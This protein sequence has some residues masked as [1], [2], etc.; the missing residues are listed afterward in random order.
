MSDIE[1]AVTPAVESDAD[2]NATTASLGRCLNCEVP[3][4]GRWCANCGQKHLD[5]PPTMAL[6]FEELIAALTH[7]DSRF[8]RTLKALLLRPGFLAREFFDGRRVSY[9]PPVRLYLGI[10]LVFF[11]WLSI[12]AA[13]DRE[14]QSDASEVVDKIESARI[15]QLGKLAQVAPDFIDP[16]SDSAPDPD[17]VCQ[18]N[19]SG[20]F[21]D[22]INS[23][24]EESCK[25]LQ[26]DGGY[27]FLQSFMRKLPTAMFMLMPLFA[28]CMK[29]WYWRPRRYFTEHL[30]LQIQN[31]S[32]IFLF[33]LMANVIERIIG[34]A[35]GSVVV[36][37]ALLYIPVYN[38]RSL[39]VYYQQGVA[40][41]RLKFFSLM[42]VYFILLSV[43]VAFTG[44]ASLLGL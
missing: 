44:V 9:L 5:G 28:V 3:L 4:T 34:G 10:S 26:Q 35:L 12:G 30:V 11:L 14:Q 21:E 25:R 17:D 40:L 31:H 37:A 41:T 23:H 2:A 29:L 22:F 42:F 32:A 1:Q 19:Y 39:R 20:E 13:W 36:L 6:F 27:E 15:E 24:F 18:S 43:I 33:A 7:A 16:E 8:W 38:Y